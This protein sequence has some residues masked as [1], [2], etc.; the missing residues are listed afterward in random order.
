[1]NL[2]NKNKNEKILK[3]FQDYFSGIFVFFI[4][5]SP[6]AFIFFYFFESRDEFTRFLNSRTNVS[7]K[8]NRKEFIVKKI[9]EKY[10][11]K[12][13]D[14]LFESKC[15]RNKRIAN[16]VIKK[17]LE[18]TDMNYQEYMTSLKGLNFYYSQK[19]KDSLFKELTRM[20]FI[21]SCGYHDDICNIRYCPPK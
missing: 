3:N 7:Q 9:A 1:M 19:Y 10:N 21:S 15:T 2:S 6:L 18:E 20:I 13:K 17:K 8:Y 11:I 12:M 5:I 14:S 16:E 4:L